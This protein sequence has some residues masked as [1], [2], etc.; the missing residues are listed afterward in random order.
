MS[1]GAAGQLQ[2]TIYLLSLNADVHAHDLEYRT[3]LHHAATARGDG[4]A[5]CL[6]QLLAAGGPFSQ[7]R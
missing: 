3:A 7:A 5:G 6:H 1:A 4:G 2:S